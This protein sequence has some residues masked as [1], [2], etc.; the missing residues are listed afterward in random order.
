M[1]AASELFTTLLLQIL[2]FQFF[3]ESPSYL[4]TR[5]SWLHVKVINRNISK[6][7]S[8]EL[9]ANYRAICF[10]L[11]ILELLVFFEAWQTLWSDCCF[12]RKCSFRRKKPFLNTIIRLSYC[13]LNFA[14]L[15]NI[16]RPNNFNLENKLHMHKWLSSSNH[17]DLRKLHAHKWRVLHD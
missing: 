8:R 10:L 13:H 2:H 7:D 16:A 14:F 3:L 5:Y 9:I 6:Q 15:F 12:N 4:Q 11:E 1:W 17:N